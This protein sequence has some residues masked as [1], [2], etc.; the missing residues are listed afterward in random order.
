M[1][2]V[3]L[4]GTLFFALGY[5]FDN[6]WVLLLS[7][8]LWFIAVI[9]LVM[10]NPIV[11]IVMSALVVKARLYFFPPTPWYMHMLWTMLILILFIPMY[12]TVFIKR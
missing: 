5:H 9:P 6:N 1:T 12:R 11:A 4:L 10:D 2:L 8:A 3:S 7:G